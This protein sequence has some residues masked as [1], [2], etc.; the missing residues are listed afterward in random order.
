LI[1]AHHAALAEGSAVV[2]GSPLSWLRFFDTLSLFACLTPPGTDEG[3]RPPWL[4]SEALRP[5]LGPRI[6]PGWRGAA[7]LSLTPYLF[8]APLELRI[9]YRDVPRRRYSRDEELRIAWLDAE[10]ES[11]TVTLASGADHP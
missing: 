4:G 5:P 6:T 8:G 11:W 3:L 7:R 9:P 1:A 10:A 2:E